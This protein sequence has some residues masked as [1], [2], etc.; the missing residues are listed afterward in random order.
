MSTLRNAI[1][2][3][4]SRDL[5]ALKPRHKASK[6]ISKIPCG[7]YNLPN[8][9]NCDA[10]LEDSCITMEEYTS[11]YMSQSMLQQN[12]QE[13]HDA[14]FYK[15]TLRSKSVNKKRRNR[16]ERTRQ[17]STERLGAPRTKS[18]AENKFK[19]QEN[20]HLDRTFVSKIPQIKQNVKSR[21]GL[22]SN[23]RISFIAK[24]P[25]HTAITPLTKCLQIE[26]SANMINKKAIDGLK[27]IRAIQSTI[28][29]MRYLIKVIKIFNKNLD[30]FNER[31]NWGGLCRSLCN[32]SEIL[33][34][35][36]NLLSQNCT[37]LDK[38]PKLIS[39]IH[40]NLFMTKRQKGVPSCSTTFQK[41]CKPFA[42]LLQ[43]IVGYYN[44]KET[45]VEER[46]HQ[47]SKSTLMQPKHRPRTTREF[48]IKAGR[49][50]EDI[51]QHLMVDTEHRPKLLKNSSQEKLQKF[52]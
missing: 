8:E 25:T 2:Q 41:E 27:K 51:S 11:Q 5:K 4:E 24:E 12:R 47:R 42:N 9:P 21:S 18:V 16:E 34:S 44:V 26:K 3:R 13:T 49:T 46:S 45:S 32:N 17:M 33:L 36:I 37:S 52:S 35:E 29:V 50:Q 22:E 20:E 30:V 28:K 19:P 39:E 38:A 48:G 14:P 15:Q 23:E 10:R 43:S 6:S 7:V 40:E 31:D 1:N